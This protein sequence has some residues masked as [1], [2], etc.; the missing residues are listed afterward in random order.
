M[1]ATMDALD[2]IELVQAG[3]EVEK[4]APALYR[5]PARNLSPA[6]P[7]RQKEEKWSTDLNAQNLRSLLS[8]IESSLIPQL[9]SSYSP[10]SALPLPRVVPHDA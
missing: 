4:R 9:M 10:A 2:V 1:R 7:R 6:A 3:T 5:S 8:I